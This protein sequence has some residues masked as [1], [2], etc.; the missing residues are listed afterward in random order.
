M[1]APLKLT[2]PPSVEPITVAEAAA[3]VQEVLALEHAGAAEAAA[4]RGKPSAR[5]P[6]QCPT[7]HVAIRPLPLASTPPSRAAS[8]TCGSWSAMSA[9]A[10]AEHWMRPGSDVLSMRDAVLTVSPKRVYLKPCA[11]TTVADA[12]PE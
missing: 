10:A 3:A 7:Q 4:P 11:P 12:G 8:G 6:A 1:T 9:A 2:Q 5:C